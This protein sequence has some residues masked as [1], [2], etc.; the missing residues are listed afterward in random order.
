M[1]GVTHPTRDALDLPS[2]ERLKVHTDVSLHSCEQL[3]GGA[4]GGVGLFPPVALV[5]AGD[6]PLVFTTKHVQVI[7][8]GGSKDREV[9]ATQQHDD[10]E[11]NIHIT[12]TNV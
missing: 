1:G 10:T 6:N 7:G 8:L 5:P 4:V 3:L 11:W 2:A 9:E 12:V